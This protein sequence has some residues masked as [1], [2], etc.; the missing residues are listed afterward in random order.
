MN[1]STTTLLNSEM[2]K[3]ETHNSYIDMVDHPA[4]VKKLTLKQLEQ[5]AKEFLEGHAA[6]IG[7]EGVC[8]VALGEEELVQVGGEQL[9]RWVPNRHGS[10]LL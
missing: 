7:S 9:L 10:R 8:G 1:S 3:S 6:S 5:L 2:A 4:H